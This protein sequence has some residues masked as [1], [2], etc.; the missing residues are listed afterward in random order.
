MLTNYDVLP[1]LVV[2]SDEVASTGVALAELGA[3]R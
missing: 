3:F 1:T 2:S